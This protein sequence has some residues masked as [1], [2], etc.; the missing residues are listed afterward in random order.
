MP[1]VKQVIKKEGQPAYLAPVGSLG[2]GSG[3]DVDLS[4][5]VDLSTDQTIGGNKTFS[6][7]V[8]VP[9]PTT[10]GIAANNKLV[11]NADYVTKEFTAHNEADETIKGAKTFEQ[12]PKVPTPEVT[13]KTN[14]P[15]LNACNVQFVQDTVSD[16]LPLSGGEMTGELILSN[17]T[18]TNPDSKQAAPISFIKDTLRA[19]VEA[20][21]SGRNTVIRDKFGNPHI[22]V[23][24]PRFNLQDIDASLGTGT[25]PAFIIDGKIK[26]EIFI[27]KFCASKGAG[28]IPVT[29]PRQV[30]WTLLGIDTAMDAAKQL[31]TGFFVCSNAAWAARAL[32]LWKHFKDE[33]PDHFYCGNTN[34]GRS[35]KFPY[36]VGT[37]PH[38]AFAPGD[39]GAWAANQHS[40]TLT[41]TGPIEWND[42]CTAWGISDFMANVWAYTSGIRLVNGEIQVIPDNNAMSP[43]VDMSPDS[44][45]WKAISSVDGTLVAPGTTGTYKFDASK[46]QTAT[47]WVIDGAPVLNTVIQNPFKAGYQANGTT[48]N[49][50]IA[51]G[52][53]VHPILKQL[54]IMTLDSACQGSIWTAM[55]GEK[56][57]CRGGSWHSGLNSGPFSIFAIDGRSTIYHH[58]GF[59]LVFSG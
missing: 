43:T 40:Y 26:S 39:T 31:G 18:D 6:Q 30:P 55:N 2:G 37:L 57:V 1:V 5:M 4:N 46:A 7:P 14:E 58:V 20:I 19:E 42:D 59:R 17:P 24:M 28:N 36:Q 33:E 10:D 21:S 3:G 11:V 23:V 13:T 44:P 8:A 38:V 52:V 49:T 9:T 34:Y 16:Y 45:E 25:H 50:Q 29:Q 22:M 32:W 51:D 53:T 15:N 54:A 47:T 41:G 48:A 56:Q 12:S 27:G 35:H